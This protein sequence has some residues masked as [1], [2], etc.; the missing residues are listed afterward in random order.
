[1]LDTNT[2]I[3][4][5]KRQPK[6]VLLRLKSAAGSGVCLSSITVCELEYGVRKSK[7]VEQNAVSLI[8]FLVGFEVVP[9]DDGAARHYGEIR[10]ALEAVGKPIGNMDL[11]IAAH[12]RALGLVLVTNNEREF[13]RIEGLSL[14]NW[15]GEAA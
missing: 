15:V 7:H 9:F 1:M 12:A 10:A 4:L 3:Y 14:E 6:V 8:R 2:C 13:R 5:I 11:L